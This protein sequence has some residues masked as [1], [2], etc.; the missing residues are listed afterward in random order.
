MAY[1]VSW[2][3]ICRTNALAESVC[4]HVLLTGIP[5]NYTK[6]L[7]L[8]FGDYVEAYE[9]TDNTSREHCSACVAFGPMGTATGPWILWKIETRTR[10]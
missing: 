6:E 2:M 10:V 3:N 9:G 7:W 5:V 8:A 1:A 4:P